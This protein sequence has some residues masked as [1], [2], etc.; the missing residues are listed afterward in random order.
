MLAVELS[1]SYIAICIALQQAISIRPTLDE[2]LRWV[3]FVY[4]CLPHTTVWET[5]TK[6]N[7]VIKLDVRKTSQGRPR[8]LMRDL[9][10]VVN[11]LVFFTQLSVTCNNRVLILL[12]YQFC[13][14]V[15]PMPVLCLNEW[16]YRHTF[17]QCG[18][19]I[20]PV[21]W[22]LPMFKKFQGKPPQRD[23][24]YTGVG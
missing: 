17:W 15:R 23:V 6:F 1:T 10:A 7:S 4:L 24:K 11:F 22:A 16:I 21:F 20:I 18:K 14:S 19:G 5:A 9:F 3:T 8:M 2:L 13:P 12:F